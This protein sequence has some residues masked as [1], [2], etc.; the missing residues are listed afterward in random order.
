MKYHDP[1][2][3]TLPKDTDTL[4]YL[5]WPRYDGISLLELA[6]YAGRFFPDTPL[7]DIEIDKEEIQIRCFGYD[8]YDST[9]YRWYITFRKV[10]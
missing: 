5:P 7:E 2:R 1:K 3:E 8:L 6:E 9:D 4:K 10:G